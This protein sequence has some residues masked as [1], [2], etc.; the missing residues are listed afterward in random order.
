MRPYIE[1]EGIGVIKDKEFIEDVGK[2][3]GSYNK[4]LLIDKDFNW[5]IINEK[6]GVW[7]EGC[8]LS[9]S[10]STESSRN[11]Y[12]S[13][14]YGNSKKYDYSKDYKSYYDRYYGY[15]DPYYDDYYDDYCKNTASKTDDNHDALQKEYNEIF[16]KKDSE[17]RKALDEDPFGYYDADTGEVF[18]EK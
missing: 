10:Y 14:N 1:Q 8:W 9:N 4:I 15:D 13:Y 5:S 18:A 3:I 2:V 6:S 11:Y 16:G 12:T 17:T 7:K